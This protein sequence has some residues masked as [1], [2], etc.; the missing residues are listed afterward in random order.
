MGVRKKVC[1]D[2]QGGMNAIAAVNCNRTLD[3]GRVLQRNKHVRI[4]DNGDGDKE[5]HTFQDKA[6]IAHIQPF[7]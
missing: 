1:S 6:N 7:V 2:L 5:G 3:R 4:S